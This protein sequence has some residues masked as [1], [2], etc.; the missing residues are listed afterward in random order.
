MKGSFGSLFL[1]S[2]LCMT[3]DLG[4]R[5]PRSYR[6][7][8][9]IFFTFETFSMTAPKQSAVIRLCGFIKYSYSALCS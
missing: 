5:Y 6:I 3:P 7:L 9:D 8:P 1:F 4:T 2:V